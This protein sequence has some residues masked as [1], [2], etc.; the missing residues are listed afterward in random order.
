MTIEL[1]SFYIAGLQYSTNGLKLMLHQDEYLS[2]VADKN[3]LNDKYAIAIFKD[4]V[5]LGYVPKGINRDV[6]EYLDKGIKIKVLKFNGDL[7]PW[8]RIEVVIFWEE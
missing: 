4:D 5:K 1:S 7:A 8:E 6:Y 2:L 3:N